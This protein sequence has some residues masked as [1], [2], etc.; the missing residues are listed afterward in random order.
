MS[1]GWYPPCY[2]HALTGLHC[3]GCGATRAAYA[4]LH[5]NLG[6]AFHQNALAVLA[7]PFLAYFAGRALWRWANAIPAPPVAPA[8][9]WAVRLTLFLV[10]VVVTFGIV[11]N[12]PWSPFN[13]LAPY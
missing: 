6:E 11:R 4:L 8:S 5:G 1:G 9:P 12:L 3:P 10:P 2:F 13:L 7:F